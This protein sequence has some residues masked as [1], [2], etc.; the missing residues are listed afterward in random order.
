MDPKQDLSS[1]LYLESQVH[2]EHGFALHD[3]LCRNHRAQYECRRLSLL[4]ASFLCLQRQLAC[5]KGKAKASTKQ[6]AAKPPAQAAPAIL[7]L[8][9]AVSTASG[10]SCGTGKVNTRHLASVQD[11]IPDIT[12]HPIFQDILTANPLGIGQG[13][14]QA[15]ETFFNISETVGRQPPEIHIRPS[16]HS[17]FTINYQIHA[18]GKQ[19]PRCLQFEAARRLR[20]YPQQYT[21]RPNK[22]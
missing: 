18:Y 2:P 19:L 1:G 11:A 13:G 7:R 16:K 22:D 12:G 6:S 9:P 15:Q 14:H 10:R 5:G 8:S 17:A 20:Y 4:L 21:P 3:I